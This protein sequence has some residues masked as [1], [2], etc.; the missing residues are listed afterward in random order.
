MRPEVFIGSH[1]FMMRPL[2]DDGNNGGMVEFFHDGQR[3]EKFMLDDTCL[4]F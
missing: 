3:S 2:K 4:W 1:F